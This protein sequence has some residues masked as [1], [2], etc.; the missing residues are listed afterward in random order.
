MTGIRRKE[1]C[2]CGVKYS[3][4]TWVV[5]VCL[6]RCCSVP[7]IGTEGMASSKNVFFN[8]CHLFLRE[9]FYLREFW[10]MY[11]DLLHVYKNAFYLILTLDWC[12]TSWWERPLRLDID[13]V[14]ILS[15]MLSS[16]KSMCQVE[17][18]PSAAL[19]RVYTVSMLLFILNGEC[20]LP[21][22]A[23]KEFFDI[24]PFIDKWCESTG[25]Y[26]RGLW[27]WLSCVMV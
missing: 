22:L 17:M 25:N 16:Y 12:W 5:F 14:A 23:G 19:F 9:N 24:V 27:C 10:F 18:M 2:L 6:Y 21:L 20:K 4:N 13:R 7:S 1:S 15:D 11:T 8:L 26:S 3:E